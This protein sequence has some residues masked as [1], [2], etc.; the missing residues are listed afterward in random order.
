M[1]DD[2]K[3]TLV[4]EGELDEGVAPAQFELDRDVVAMVLDGTQTDAELPR[5]LAARQAVG[6]ES[7]NAPL[8]RGELLER[9]FLRHQ[10]RR[11]RVAA[12]EKR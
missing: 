11:A 10:T 8:R 9:R 2:L 1:R 6:H 5:D 7:Q 4:L 12:D 3:V